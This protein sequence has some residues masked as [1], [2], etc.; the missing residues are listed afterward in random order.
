[1]SRK[2]RS[3]GS[4]RSVEAGGVVVEH[5][6][7]FRPGEAGENVQEPLDLV[8][9]ADPEAR[10]REVGCPH[11]ALDPEDPDRLQDDPTVTLDRPGGIL[12]AQLR[13]L[14]MRSEE[15]TS[16]LQSLTRIS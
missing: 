5:R 4:L 2:I 6:F 8:A 1:M 9:V 12:Q 3:T 13:Q 15:H 7:E 16:E 14:H 11:A 10:R